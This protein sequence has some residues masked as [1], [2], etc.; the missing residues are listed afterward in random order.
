YAGDPNNTF[1]GLTFVYIIANDP[2]SL[3]SIERFTAINFS[4]LLTDAGFAPTGPAVPVLIDRSLQGDT[5]GFS[6]FSGIGP[7][8][9]LPGQTSAQLIIRTNAQSFTTVHDSIIDGAVA[10][11]QA[12]GPSLIPEPATCGLLALGA[13]A[14]AA[15]ARRGKN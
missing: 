6:F 10:S 14:F 13:M 15:C 8:S 9:I 5:V 11:V 12:F 4:G 1:G 3:D 7:G 2:T